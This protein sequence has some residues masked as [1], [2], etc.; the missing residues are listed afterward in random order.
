MR[1]VELRL[2]PDGQAFPGVDA[3]IGSVEGVRREALVALEWHSDGTY[4]LLYRLAGDDAAALDAVFRDR[5]DVY[6]YDVI[7]G[8]DGQL[9]AFVHVSERETLSELLAIAE[10]YALLLDPPFRYTDRGVRVTVAGT[11]A[12]LQAAFA[13]A[14]DRI[15]VE[16]EWT[17][18]YTPDEPG[19]L[20]R[21]TDRQ[22]EAVL[23][24]HELGYY[25]T[26]RAT[27]FEAVAE[28]LGCAP[29]TANELLRR[30]ESVLLD[31]LLAE[32]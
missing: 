2:L 24:A 22:R 26:P 14:I 27:S 30:A 5:A 17:G 19:Y 4:A 21:L 28:E 9:F 20:G 23:V 3:A 8:G 12:A 15:A 10:S 25:E 13:E 1:A 16:I 29:S 6:D 31:A 7:D 18:E 32:S 11:E